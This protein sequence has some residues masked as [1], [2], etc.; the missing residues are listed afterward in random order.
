MED[1]EK[2]LASLKEGDSVAVECNRKYTITKI[3]R[4]TPTRIIKTEDGHAFKSGYMS[5]ATTWGYGKRLVPI[6]QEVLDEIQ[7]R[8]LEYQ[9][10]QM[11]TNLLTLDQLERIAAI[12]SESTCE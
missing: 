2:F 7:R 8:K 12:L 6:T 11:K 4:I 9:I 5:S 1:N 3:T 10:S